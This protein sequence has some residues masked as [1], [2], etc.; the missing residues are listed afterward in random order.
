MRKVVYSFLVFAVLTLAGCTLPKMVKMSK[1]QQLTVTPNPLEVHK[2]T[3]A[4]DLAANLPVKMLKKGTVYTLNS[5]Y[6]YGTSELAL[7]PIPFKAEDYPNSKTEAPRVT[8]SFSFPYQPAYKVGTLEVEGVASKGE[9]AKKTPRLP[10]ATGI[11][12]T[13][14]LVKPVSFA[15]FAEHGYNNQEE[16]VPVVIPDFIFE[17]GRSVLRP[18]EIKSTKGKQLDAFIASKNATRTVTITGTHSPEGAERINA[19]LSPDRAAAIEKFYRA[20]M[21][22]YDYKGK[23][24]SINFILKP[25]IQDWNEFKTALSSYEGI[26]SEEKAEYLNIINAGGSFEDVEKQF[27]KLKTYKK[28][29]KD[30]YPKLRTAKTEILIVKDKKTDAEISVLSKQVTQGSV[31]ADTLSFEELMYAA[32]LTPSLEEKAAIYEAATKKGSNWN[33]HNNLGAVYIAQANENPSNAAAL[34]DKAQ[35]Q[36]DLAVKLN[37][38]PEVHAN[39]ASVAALKGN[40]YA[41]YSHASKALGAGLRG[42]NAAGVNGVKG[43]AEI[44]KAQYA[45]AVSSESSA[46]DNADNLFNKGLAQVL[47]KDYQNALTSFKEAT[48]K[49]SNLAIAYYGAAVASARLGNA[50][51]VVS[52]LGSAVK[53]DPSLKEAALSDLEFDKFKAS[54]AFKGA[55]K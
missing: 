19:K 35:A 46:T 48:N 1:D 22:K 37:E 21:K 41:A 43:Y 23:A 51:G 36:L 32:T 52:N 13:S 28:V 3:V 7:D 16:L 11:I 20:E 25:V 26:S 55:L 18:T 15:A 44:V 12:T 29:F 24:D 54:E 9:K 8:K 5:F 2:D 39:L 4:F 10:V 47:N 40:A 49:N 30:V 17:Q 27:K 31:S 42:D 45:A 34:A 38:A 6:K 53:A 14:K 33:A 50:E